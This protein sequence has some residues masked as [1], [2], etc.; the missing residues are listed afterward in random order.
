M[1]PLAS[2]FHVRIKKLGMQIEPHRSNMHQS[3]ELLLLA[4]MHFLLAIP[5]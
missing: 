3:V 4:P 2:Y 5:I 1:N